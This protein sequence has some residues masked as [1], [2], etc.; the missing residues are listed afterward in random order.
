MKYLSDR[1]AQVAF[2]ALTLAVLVAAWFFWSRDLSADPPLHFFRLSQSLATDPALY[3]YHAK[4]RVLFDEA[5]PMDDTRW[6][7]FEKSFA[8]FLATSWFRAVGISIPHG[9]Q[10]GMA[11]T[12]AGFLLLLAGIWR[13]HRPWVAAAVAAVLATNILLFVYGTYPFLEISLLFFSGLVFFTYSLWGDR[14]WGLVLSG[15]GIAA[16]TFAGKIFGII[17]LP[18]LIGCELVT[19]PVGSRLK[20]SGIALGA[21]VVASVILVTLLYGS[22]FTDAFGF[23][24]EQAYGAKGLPQGLSSPWQF[25]AFLLIYGYHNELYLACPDLLWSFVVAGTLLMIGLSNKGRFLQRIPR[26]TLFALGWVLFTW[27]GLAPLH[28]SPV[29]YSLTFIPALTVLCFTLI[30]SM[31]SLEPKW[32]VA[33]GWW[34]AMGVG[35][36][37][38]VLTA[39]LALRFTHNVT[40]DFV[41]TSYMVSTL[42]AGLI[43]M[44]TARFLFTRLKL[45]LNRTV[46]GVTATVT[47]LVALVASALGYSSMG[48]GKRSYQ[49]TTANADIASLLGPGAVLS[50]PYAA[51][52]TQENGINAHLHFFGEAWSD[53]SWLVKLPITHLA[54]DGPNSEKAFAQSRSLESAEPITTYVLGRNE[55][56]VFNISQ[57][58]DN[59]AANAYKASR[60][61]QAVRYFNTFQYDSAMVTLSDE[62]EV[63]G[64]SRSAALLYTRSMFRLNLY[65]DALHNYQRLRLSYPTDFTISLEAANAVHQVSEIRGDSALY[66]LAMALYEQAVAMNPLETAYINRMAMETHEH[67]EKQRQA[68]RSN[69]GDQ[70]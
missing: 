3:T 67:F 25:V 4:N 38:W 47:V 39:Q 37:G 18:V 33:F 57:I 43:C 30:N 2:V 17:L 10:V 9:R 48:L 65:D 8:G 64:R 56:S 31:Q 63:L 45:H 35:I 5:D 55:V 62:P 44:V 54:V 12:F 27:V 69:P 36:V 20:R 19:A 13:H 24:K 68:L 6:I 58:Y 59:P 42:P 16:A 66:N 40:T 60:Y 7:L 22:H 26:T 41:P 29:R 34:P 46:L 32:K 70:R 28:F 15:I 49:I 21:F 50:G 14:W 51:A 52:L 11:L 53:S 23:L 1:S 61:E